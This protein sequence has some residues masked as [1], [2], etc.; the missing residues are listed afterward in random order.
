MIVARAFSESINEPSADPIFWIV[1][2][3]VLRGLAEKSDPTLQIVAKESEFHIDRFGQDGQEVSRISEKGRC[4]LWTAAFLRRPMIFIQLKSAP[5]NKCVEKITKIRTN[6][7][8]QAQTSLG[9]PKIAFLL[10]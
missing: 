3:D 2:E 9:L 7:G 4:I 1:V 5:R 6:K 8:I 10:V